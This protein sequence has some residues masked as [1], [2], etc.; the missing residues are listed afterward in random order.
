[1]HQG[2]PHRP[3][4][5][6][7]TLKTTPSHFRTPPLL[8]HNLTVAHKPRRCAQEEARRLAGENMV[9]RAQIA[10]LLDV[11]DASCLVFDSATNTLVPGKP[12]LTSSHDSGSGDLGSG[13]DQCSKGAIVLA[14]P[15]KGMVGEEPSPS[16]VGDGKGK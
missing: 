11:P 9:M 5:L 10:T 14:A 12:M 6:E 3:N 1:M 13:E 8:P 2:F 7:H 4:L 15:A 16:P